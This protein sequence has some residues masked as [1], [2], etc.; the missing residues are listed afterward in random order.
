M[1][2]HSW[3]WRDD[4]MLRD[5]KLCL[6]LSRREKNLSRSEKFFL[7]LYIFLSRPLVAGRH[8]PV[9][10]VDTLLVVITP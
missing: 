6:A 9:K 4:K 7:R 3:L 1:L 5:D 2:I 10:R 8:V